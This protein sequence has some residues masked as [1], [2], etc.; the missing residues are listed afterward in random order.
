MDAV[1]FLKVKH[2][3]CLNYPHCSIC[4]IK[5]MCS[6]DD[7]FDEE[8]AVTRVEKWSKEHPV[9]TRMSEFLKHYPDAPIQDDGMP[10]ASPC[11]LDKA[12]YEK[13]CALNCAKCREKYWLEEIE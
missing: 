1:K 7:D 4:P 13:E 8:K 5:G 12:Y 11:N 3:M 2:R 9:K 10:S 6:P